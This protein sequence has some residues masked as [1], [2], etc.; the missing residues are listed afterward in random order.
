MATREITSAIVAS[1]SAVADSLRAVNALAVVAAIEAASIAA[2]AKRT[3]RAAL[4]AAA[5]TIADATRQP[6]RLRATVF[7]FPSYTGKAGEV[8]ALTIH[9]SVPFMARKIVATD[10][11]QAGTSIG[12]IF[13][14]NRNQRPTLDGTTP[15]MFFGPTTIGG[16]VA[17]D[18]CEPWETIT[19]KV[20]FHVACTFDAS[21]FGDMELG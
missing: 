11:S 20:H 2:I 19:I 8:V 12:Q 21:L 3:A 9:P 18:R 14:G 7:D 17:F 13:V 5:V 15:T 16:G 1:A 10:A 4:Y 6:K